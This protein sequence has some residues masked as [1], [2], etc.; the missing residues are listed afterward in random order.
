MANSRSLVEA[1]GTGTYLGDLLEMQGICEVF[2]SSHTPSKPLIIG[3]SKTCLGHT[4]SAAGL[5]GVAKTLL[6]FKHHMVP[7]LVHLTESNI[8][9]EIDCESVPLIIPWKNTS[10]VNSEGIDNGAAPHRAM[11][12]SVNLFDVLPYPH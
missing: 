8:N 3:A 6:S 1:H 7:G 10:L 5:V 11:V 4:E 12:L 9:G 2:D